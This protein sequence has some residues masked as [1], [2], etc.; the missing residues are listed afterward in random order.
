M[1]HDFHAMLRVLAQPVPGDSG[2]DI[3]YSTDL[4]ACPRDAPNY[5]KQPMIV[6]NPGTSCN[7]GFEPTS[8]A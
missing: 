6:N 4:E 5:H 8:N 7:A 1:R 3:E 2:T